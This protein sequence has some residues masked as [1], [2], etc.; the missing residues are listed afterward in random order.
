MKTYPNILNE[1]EGVAEM[2]KTLAVTLSE[3]KGKRIPDDV[4]LWV[5]AAASYAYVMLRL[6]VCLAQHPEWSQE[7]E[8]ILNKI[9]VGCPA[10]KIPL[11]RF[12]LHKKG[13]SIVENVPI[14]TL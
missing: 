10:Q 11:I 2:S 3:H 8:E 7:L 14:V 6:A 9:G 12:F 4:N 1:F 13:V 5:I